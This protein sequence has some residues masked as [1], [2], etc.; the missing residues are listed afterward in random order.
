MNI[1]NKKPLIL[2]AASLLLA[3]P[4]A[5]AQVAPVKAKVGADANAAGQVNAAHDQ[6]RDK[7]GAKGEVDAQAQATPPATPATPAVPPTGDATQA[8]PAVPATPA[9]PV[10]QASGEKKWSDLDGDG[11]GTLSASEAEGMPSLAKI[12]AEADADANGELSQ[13]EYKAWV[14]NNNAAR[15]NNDPSQGK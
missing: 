4:I 9:A 2:T 5:M 8:T 3:A 6:A 13:D 11:N 15:S 14:A 7:V 1:Q 12:F 10:A